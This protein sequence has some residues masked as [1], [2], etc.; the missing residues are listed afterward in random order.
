MGG[1]ANN[2]NPDGSL[3]PK[4]KIKPIG[5][6]TWYGRVYGNMYD[7]TEEWATFSPIQVTHLVGYNLSLRRSAFTCFENKLKPYWQMF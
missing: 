4:R 5:K 3:F 7:Q 6:L 1:S 2:H